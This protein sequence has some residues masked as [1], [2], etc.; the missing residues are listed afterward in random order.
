MKEE[1]QEGVAVLAIGQRAEFEVIGSPVI[2]VQQVGR[3]AGR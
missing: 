2:A 1:R 3:Q